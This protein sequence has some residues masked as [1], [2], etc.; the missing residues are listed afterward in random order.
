MKFN[1]IF[2]EFL[3][4]KTSR[5]VYNYLNQTL[6]DSITGW[7]YFVN[8]RKVIANFRE[9]ELHLNTLNYL[10]GKSDIEAELR[11]ILEQSPGVFNAIPILIACR[12]ANFPILTNYASENFQYKKFN[13]SK[14]WILTLQEIDAAIEF[15]REVGVLELFQNK[16]IKSIPDYVLGIEVGLDS[17]GRKNRG[18]D[19][20][21]IIVEE[22][23]K[24]LSTAN[25]FSYLKQATSEK[26]FKAW[27]IVVIADKT[28]RRFDF[29]INNQGL[30][31]LIEVNFYGGAGSKLKAT[32]GEYK[33]LF[34]LL[35][36]QNHQFIWLTDGLG[37]KRSLKPLE[38]TFNHI[39][40]TLNLNMSSTGLLAEIIKRKL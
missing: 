4:C 5:G 35:S 1:S 22:M 8:W 7:D 10:I 14:K 37:W 30:L 3:N 26:I 40:Y 39:D 21:E 2:D 20:M 31:Y 18:G 23:V 36:P 34:D 28:S 24:T 13:F 19:M 9:V 32:A 6:T 17:N 29:A 27:D 15:V 16:T 11:L 33:A 12:S 25:N 38:E